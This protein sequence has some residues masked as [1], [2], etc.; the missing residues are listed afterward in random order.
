[1]EEA[2]RIQNFFLRCLG[3][4]ITEYY[5][6]VIVAENALL[7]EIED[8]DLG[9]QDFTVISCFL[10]NILQ[11]NGNAISCCTTSIKD[12]CLLLS[13]PDSLIVKCRE[14]ATQLDIVVP[15]IDELRRE[16]RQIPKG[17]LWDLKLVQIYFLLLCF[18]NCLKQVAWS[19]ASLYLSKLLLVVCKIFAPLVSRKDIFDPHSHVSLSS[20]SPLLSF[21]QL[22]R[23]QFYLSQ[24]TISKVEPL[25]GEIEDL[26]EEIE[27]GY[28][29]AQTFIQ[30][31]TKISYFRL[32]R[33]RV[34][35]MKADKEKLALAL[36]WYRHSLEVSSFI[37]LSLYCVH[38]KQLELA[39]K[40]GIEVMKRRALR[41]LER[42]RDSVLLIKKAAVFFQNKRKAVTFRA[43]QKY[44]HERLYKRSCVKRASAL[45]RRKRSLKAIDT[46]LRN[47]KEQKL[48]RRAIVY[49]SRRILYLTLSAWIHDY[50]DFCRLRAAATIIQSCHRRKSQ[51]AAFDL[52]KRA[53]IH[54]FYFEVELL[55]KIMKIKGTYYLVIAH[56]KNLSFKII[57]YDMHSSQYFRIV[58]PEQYVLLLLNMHASLN[59]HI[60][61]R[62]RIIQKLLEMIELKK[63]RRSIDIG[64]LFPDSAAGEMIP[65][66]HGRIFER[67][68]MAVGPQSFSPSNVQWYRAKT[69][70]IVRTGF[71]E[72]YQEKIISSAAKGFLEDT[73]NRVCKLVTWKRNNKEN[74]GIFCKRLGL[75]TSI[76]VSDDYTRTYH[77][78]YITLYEGR[79]TRE[80]SGRK[81]G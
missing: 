24:G 66:I 30:T 15:C 36:Q 10:R 45:W 25:L 3:K 55:R 73:F 1:M 4:T 68:V 14:V 48:R 22:H 35:E 75:T 64:I 71:Q 39:A 40:H 9:G 79:V 74:C 23:A 2:R 17:G 27:L 19:E 56:Q 20:Y 29:M 47:R 34:E 12:L 78:A 76:N 62:D 46:F 28:D 26:I 57:L 32:W 58:I 69:E 50:R 67:K 5:K 60:M 54:G 31:N 59:R 43:W 49:F 63:L 41:L 44:L 38:R 33:T 52:F 61:T 37:K 11:R 77:E 21:V 6:R 8:F 7:T 16:G 51:I 13:C 80:G 42:Y 53:C 65:S 70:M 81:C 18:D 72:I